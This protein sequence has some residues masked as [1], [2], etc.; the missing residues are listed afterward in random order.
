MHEGVFIICFLF[1]LYISELL[2]C[3]DVSEIMSPKIYGM[4]MDVNQNLIIYI[5]KFA[6][7]GGCHLKKL[8]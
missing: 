8:R 3:Y 6:K 4:Y 7:N 2:C 1:S 5:Y